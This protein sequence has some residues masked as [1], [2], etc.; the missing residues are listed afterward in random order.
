V[1]ASD[2]EEETGQTYIARGLSVR[3]DWA[4]YQ[5]MYCYVIREFDKTSHQVVAPLSCVVLAVSGEPSFWYCPLRS[6]HNP[7]ASQVTRSSAVDQVILPSCLC[8]RPL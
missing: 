6:L 7:E 5:D 4:T 8:R 2:E 3:V 1:V